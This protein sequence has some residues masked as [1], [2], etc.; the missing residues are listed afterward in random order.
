[1]AQIHLTEQSLVDLAEAE[2][3]DNGFADLAETDV[4][5]DD[6]VVFELSFEEK[7]AV[8]TDAVVRHPLNREIL[9]KILAFCR[10]ERL[11]RT[12][13]EEVATYP[14]FA[15][16]TQNQYHMVSTLVKAHGLCL[17]ERD[18]DGNEVL[19]HQKEGLTEDE[20]DDLVCS[21]NYVTTEVGERFVEIHQPK[22]RLVELLGLN[23]QR[24]E[25][26][27]DVLRFVSEK[28]RSYN[29]IRGLL[30]GL[31][32]LETVIDGNT[33]TMQPSVFVDKLERNGALVWDRGWRLTKEGK[34]FLEDLIAN[35]T[36][37]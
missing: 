20:I 24:S 4:A 13:E 1:M 15:L 30:E 12:V 18:V 6:Q 8:L 34:E 14:E 22:A 36:A 35:E 16:A 37:K 33:V 3:Q 9:Y 27:I 32:A 21:L 29:E 25:T 28:P 17:V 23:P 11:L 19:P 2:D 5:F 26:Y 10:E 31:P 7:L